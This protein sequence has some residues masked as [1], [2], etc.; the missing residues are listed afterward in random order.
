MKY[1]EDMG[2]FSER[3]AAGKFRYLKLKIGREG[4]YALADEYLGDF[5]SREIIQKVGTLISASNDEI[6]REKNSPIDSRRRVACQ[7]QLHANIDGP[8][9][10]QKGL[11]DPYARIRCDNARFCDAG[12]D[13]SRLY[14]LLIRIIREDPDSR[15]R[16]AA[17]M[18]LSQSF[19][20]L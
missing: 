11:S 3:S 19:A 8:N 2:I 4:Y 17:G 10:F 6:L 16:K 1:R 15:V 9:L 18:S 14:N 5:P 12:E 20:D 13:R 7:L